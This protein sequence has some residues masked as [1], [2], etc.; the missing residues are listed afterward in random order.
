VQPGIFLD[1]YRSFVPRFLDDEY[2]RENGISGQL[3]ILNTGFTF[4]F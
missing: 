1:F 4:R 2:F 3:G